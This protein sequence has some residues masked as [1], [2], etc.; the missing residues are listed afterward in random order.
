[1][2]ITSDSNTEVTATR[3]IE[4]QTAGSK[5][6][7]AGSD[8]LIADAGQDK[9]SFASVLDRV[10]NSHHKARDTSS[11]EGKS[12]ASSKTRE[13]DEDKVDDVSLANTD[14]TPAPEPVAT[15]EVETNSWPIVHTLDLDSI[16]TA[17][18][19]QLAGNGQKAV[20]LELSHSML[21]GLR[22]KLTS[23]GAGRITADFLAANEGVKSVIDGRSMELMEVL[24]SRGINLAEFRSSVSADANSRND[25]QE[26]QTAAGA[27]RIGGQTKAVASLEETEVKENELA[28]G[29]TY[30]A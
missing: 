25:S 1:M 30:R 3:K 6:G 22:V 20:M 27:E 15:S 14:R 17:C 7:L 13:R 18:Q 9:S 19:V 28:A 16:V 5:P 21:E 12:A 2:K 29:A 24:R 23:D 8:S 11:E 10:T 4:N 26:R